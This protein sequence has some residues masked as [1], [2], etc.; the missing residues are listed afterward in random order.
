MI[1]RFSVLIKNVNYPKLF[2]AFFLAYIAATLII[3]VAPYNKILFILLV[4]IYLG[5]ILSQKIELSKVIRITIAPFV[6][7]GV[8]LYGTL[9]ALNIPHNAELLKQFGL[10]PLTLFLIYPIITFQMDM[11]L[12]IKRSGLILSVLTLVFF[13]PVYLQRFIQ[14]ADFGQFLNSIIDYLVKYG[15]VA[16]GYRYFGSFVV[17]MMHFGV[18]PYL[19]ATFCVIL[20]D[21]LKT[22][23]LS[24]FFAIVIVFLAITL[25]T[26]RALLICIFLSTLIIVFFPPKGRHD[27][28]ILVIVFAVLCIALWLLFPMIVAFFNPK[29]YSNAIKIGH[30]NSFFTNLTFDRALIGNGLATNY[31][32]KGVNTMIAHTEMTLLD[33]VRYFGI[34]LTIVFFLC[35]LR[36][37]KI[38]NYTIG[39]YKTTAIGIVYFVMLSS[40]NPTLLNS[41]GSLVLL[42]YWEMLAEQWQTN[43]TFHNNDAKQS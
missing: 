4:L 31:Y 35:V 24:D 12:F 17:P 18:N 41:Y 16:V 11:N 1:T 22:K 21:L 38:R 7:A 43:E 34:P 39:I 36:P 6:I 23:R 3:P 29:E 8:F 30:L 15:S 25:S 28:I 33:L 42:W 10:Y 13:I 14:V 5:Y 26:S 27:W 40:T 37:Y 20:S 32:S 19:F 9:L 2:S